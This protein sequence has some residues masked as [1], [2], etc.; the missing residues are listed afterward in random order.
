MDVAL[1]YKTVTC[2]ARMPE[3]EKIKGQSSPPQLEKYA[4]NLP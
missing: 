2:R 3:L 1:P 4:G